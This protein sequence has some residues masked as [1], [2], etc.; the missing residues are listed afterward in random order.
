VLRNASSVETT[1]LVVYEW[2]SDEPVI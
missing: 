1:F 2:I